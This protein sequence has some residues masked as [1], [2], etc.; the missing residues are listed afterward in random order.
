MDSKSAPTDFMSGSSSLPTDKN[1]VNTKDLVTDKVPKLTQH[2]D[3]T[4]S[5][6][7]EAKK[8]LVNSKFINFKF[9]KVTRL[10]VDP[11]VSNQNYF[12]SSFI[13][14]KGAVPDKDGIFGLFKMR[15]AF[16][17]EY[18]AQAHCENIIAK[19]D[20]NN[21]LTIGYPGK[22]FPITSDDK[23]YSINEVS[24][25]EA[26]DSTVREF[27][28]KKRQQELQEIQEIEKRRQ[29][30]YN[31]TKNTKENCIDDLDVYITLRT[32]RATLRQYTEDL[33]KRL[34]QLHEQI[35]EQTK[36]IEGLDK[37]YPTYNA[38][39]IKKYTEQLKQIGTDIKDSPLLK[40][41]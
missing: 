18:E 9:P 6:V 31:D 21:E 16:S 14:S 20:S 36:E 11:Q 3:L 23:F 1:I 17:H 39:F 26:M 38:D 28:K 40:Y 15:G 4:E 7:Q 35:K 12:V 33:S 24:Q 37:Q 27:K 10:D 19:I 29:E 13:P 25:K 2:R 41:M 32:K 34:A 22:W 5:E 8:E 30:L